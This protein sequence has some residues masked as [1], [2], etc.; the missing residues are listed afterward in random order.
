[1]F[2]CRRGHQHPS[3]SQ[4]RRCDNQYV[5]DGIVPDLPDE[6]TGDF[7]TL[8]IMPDVTGPAIDTTPGAGSF[9]GFGGGESGGGGGGGD[10]GG[11]SGGGDSGS[12]GGD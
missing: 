8:T 7:G 4:K 6:H 5:G 1:M 12:T 10:W 11:D 2:R 9:G 3:L